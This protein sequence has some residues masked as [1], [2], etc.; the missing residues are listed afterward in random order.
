MNHPKVSI[1]V[2]NWN[3]L[4]DTTEL[5][6]SLKK[7]SYPNYE[8][9][10]VD[11]ASDGGDAQILKD[12][13]G[14]YIQTIE[15][16]KNYGWGEGCNI[17]IRHALENS[18][19][20]YILIMDSDV[21]VA[22]ECL[23]ELVSVAESDEQIGVLG[24]KIYHFDYHGKKG[25]IWSAGGRI[26]WWGLKI[27]T[28]IGEGDDDLSKYQAEA[29]VDWITGCVMMFRSSL[30]EVVGF[31][32]PWYFIGHEDIE[33]CLK[34]RKHGFKVVYVPTAEAWHKVGAS[35][36]KAHIT[37]ADPSAYYY[38]IRNCFP[39]RVYV[40]HLLLMPALMSRWAL[41]YL[42]R[43]RDIYTLRRFLSDFARFALATRKRDFHAR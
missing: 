25:V 31:L 6:E 15:N 1:V 13:F 24:P 26:R 28:Q 29:T 38:L 5:L 36:K 8:V 27:H 14:E 9:I 41:L 23:S 19:P 17:G 22:P 3:G 4:E 21:V 39:L 30:T 2:L 10:V 40:Y 11:N 37:F 7:I 35:T 34:A 32:N 42:I 43:Y 18:H 16:E 12:R 33:F 20:E